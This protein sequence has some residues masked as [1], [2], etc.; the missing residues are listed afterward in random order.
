MLVV[1][2][3]IIAE[4]V[5]GSVRVKEALDSMLAIVAVLDVRIAHLGILSVVSE[6][7]SWRE[8]I[9]SYLR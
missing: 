4:K 3:L 6:G 7:K 1:K 2:N 5:G 8:V 9:E